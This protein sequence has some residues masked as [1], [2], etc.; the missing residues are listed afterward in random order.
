MNV[1]LTTSNVLTILCTITACLPFW[2]KT[3]DLIFMS[4][5]QEKGGCLWLWP[6]VVIVG[7]SLRTS[8]HASLI[9]A[10]TLIFSVSAVNSRCLSPDPNWKR[11]FKH[12]L[13]F[14]FRRQLG[15]EQNDTKDNQYN[16]NWPKTLLFWHVI[17]L[18]VIY[19]H[20]C[21]LRAQ[22]S[23]RALTICRCSLPPSSG[24]RLVDY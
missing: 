10:F 24:V 23:F 19:P 3:G 14:T 7:W 12:L 5:E 22:S 9:S 2:F 17:T 4:V 15:N 21:S 16:R 1:L 13:C 20:Y 18:R 11:H 6:F 8:R